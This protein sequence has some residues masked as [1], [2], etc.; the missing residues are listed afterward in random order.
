VG[1][2]RLGDLVAD[3]EE[4]VQRRLRVLEDVGDRPPRSARISSE[5]SAGRAVEQTRRR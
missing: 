1:A 5:T 3:G 2:D 4:R